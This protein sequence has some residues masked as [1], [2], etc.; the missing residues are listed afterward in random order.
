MKKILIVE[1]N[2]NVSESLRDLL[3]ASGYLPNLAASGEI[4]LEVL[5]TNYVPDLIISDIMMPGID[6]YQLRNIISSKP[7]LAHLPFIFLTAKSQ[8]EDIRKGMNIGADDYL[9]KPYKAADLLN[10]IEIRLNKKETLD[11]KIEIITR[12]FAFYVPHELRTPLVSILGYSGLLLAEKN[13]I[14]KEEI[15]YMI[16]RINNS[17]KR[18]HDTIEKFI[19]FT[20][21]NR[22]FEDKEYFKNLEQPISVEADRIIRTTALEIAKNFNRQDDVSINLETVDL[23]MPLLLFSTLIKQVVENSFKFSKQKET[24]KISSVLNNG[25]YN[26]SIKDEGIGMGNDEIKM[27]DA[28]VQFKRNENQQIGNGLGLMIT[29]MIT[30]NYGGKLEIFSELNEFTEVKITLPVK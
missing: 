3:E 29:K 16:D 27:I 1:D 14:S 8:M 2:P 7:N 19:L 23:E 15:F 28:F 12:N 25:N 6:G 22:S 30:N 24:V 11:K 13:E 4:A 9:T 5:N 21:I 26:I 20:E 17:A 18:L 10:A